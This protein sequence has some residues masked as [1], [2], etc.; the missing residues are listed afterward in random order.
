MKLIKLFVTV[1]TL[2]GVSFSNS[3]AQ[4]KIKPVVK[5]VTGNVTAPKIN[6]TQ[7]LLANVNPRDLLTEVENFVTTKG[8]WPRA[9]EAS[10]QEQLL[11]RRASAFMFANRLDRTIVVQLKNLYEQVEQAEFEQQTLVQLENFINTQARWPRTEIR[12]ISGKINKVEDMSVEQLDE[13]RLAHQIEYI[14]ARDPAG[15][16][17]Q[18]IQ[19][20]K[21]KDK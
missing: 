16:T 2:L 17:A 18:K 15:A 21:E 1:V 14:L 4:K 8:R 5:A 19:S 3:Y 7:R 13:F 20:L 9:Y 12:T 10:K 11:A 6:R